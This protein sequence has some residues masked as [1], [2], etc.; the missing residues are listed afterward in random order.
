MSYMQLGWDVG[1]KALVFMLP[2]RSNIWFN[3]IACSYPPFFSK[4]AAPE[5]PAHSFC[6][7]L[8]VVLLKNCFWLHF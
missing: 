6:G 5:A 3:M 8:N 7:N 4:V 1:V 2:K